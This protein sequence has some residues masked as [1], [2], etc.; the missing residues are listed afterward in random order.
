MQVTCLDEA[1]LSYAHQLARSSRIFSLDEM[2]LE[3]TGGHLFL[4]FHTTFS[5]SSPSS[6]FSPTT[7]TTPT[8][9]TRVRGSGGGDAHEFW[10]NQVWNKRVQKHALVFLLSCPSYLAHQ[11]DYHHRIDTLTASLQ[12]HNPHLRLV[13]RCFAFD[14][15]TTTSSSSTSPT[16]ATT[17]S[18]SSSSSS[19]EGGGVEVRKDVIIVPDQNSQIAFYLHTLMV[20]LCRDVVQAM[21]EWRLKLEKNVWVSPPPKYPYATSTTTTTTTAT[22]ATHYPSSLLSLQR[23]NHARVRHHS[24]YN[25]N[26]PGLIH[27]DKRI[28]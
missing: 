14:P 4:Q 17:T 5:P 12:R 18:G 2:S 26:I 3:R 15:T 27:L 7:P 11:H 24:N 23:Q 8:T 1:S 9:P 22:T 16:T 20:D 21:Q 25:F 28:C 13:T 6:P 10:D 19:I